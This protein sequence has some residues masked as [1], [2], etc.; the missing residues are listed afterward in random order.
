VD[1]KVVICM[2][3]EFGSGGR[4]VGEKLAEILGIPFYD[5]NLLAKAAMENG[6]PEESVTALDE[7]PL[8]WASMGIPMGMRSPYKNI[9]D[10]NTFYVMND[11]V[12]NILG[13]TIMGIAAEGSCIIVGRASEEIL[14]EDPDMVSIFI[15]ADKAFRIKRISEFERVS[16]QEAEQIIKKMDK[17]RANYNNYYSEKKWG[18]C[19]SYDFSISTSKFGIDGAVKAVLNL[20]DLK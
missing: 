17:K 12:F 19:A 7:Q 8:G 9:H 15:H 13:K 20:L 1:K 2:N 11:W 14:K 4:A 18:A 3:R 6:V 5:K 16:V 10:D